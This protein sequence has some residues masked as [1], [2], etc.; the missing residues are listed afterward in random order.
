MGEAHVSE[1]PQ[2]K[3]TTE[4]LS[5]YLVGRVLADCRTTRPKLSEFG[6]RVRGRQIRRLWCKGKHIFMDFG[7]DLFL[8]N[9]LL[10]RGSW[11]K[12]AGRLLL[13]PE[14]MWLALEV[15]H[16]TVC[17]YHGQL[18]RTLDGGQVAEQLASLGPDVMDPGCAPA[19]LAAAL[20]SC[21]LPVG[22]AMLEQS[23]L[24]GVGN[25]AKSEALFLAGVHPEGSVG[26]L[27]EDALAKLA[28]AIHR[29]MWDSYHAGG[30]W[31]HRVYRRAGQ[32]CFEC[33]ARL[34]LIRQGKA[35]RSTYFCPS[36]QRA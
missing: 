11:R 30:R 31:T 21:R 10:M 16:I 24:C 2:V 12:V 22:E 1:G 18:L 26:E 15:D 32:R 20:A 6:A 14:E 5:R 35:A 4:R 23:L 25:V 17:N 33:G 34:R 19:D 13:L 3:L 9:H 7:D 36:C 29:V 28:H 27:S 8:Q